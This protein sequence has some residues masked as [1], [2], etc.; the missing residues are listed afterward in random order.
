MPRRYT[1]DTLPVPASDDVRLREVPAQR[2]AAIRFGGV[3]TDG[4]LAE[5]EA[6]LRGWLRGRGLDATGAPLY[7]YY[8][9][10][11]TPGVFRRNEVLIDLP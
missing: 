5:K 11:S 4:L 2:R 10:P 8:N 1:L 7:A 6:A 9:D 3:A